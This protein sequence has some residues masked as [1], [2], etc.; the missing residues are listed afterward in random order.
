MNPL[1]EFA[2]RDAVPVE[3]VAFL[4]STS[5]IKITLGRGIQVGLQLSM[6]TLSLIMEPIA[7]AATLGGTEWRAA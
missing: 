1:W 7:S 4:P 2:A 6:S 5:S 3:V